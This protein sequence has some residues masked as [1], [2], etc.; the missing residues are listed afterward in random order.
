[1]KKLAHSARRLSQRIHYDFDDITLLE[2]ALTHS[3]TR[4]AHNERLEFLGDAV[5]EVIIS[6]ALFKQHPEASEGPLTRLRANLVCERSLV[7]IAVDLKLGDYLHL[8]QGEKKS[9]GARRD[10]ILADA[11]EALIGAIYLDSDLVCCEKYVLAWFADKLANSK[12]DTPGLK[13]PKST[14][15]EYAQSRGQTLPIYRIEVIEG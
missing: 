15:Q 6:S 7:D 1:M 13:D 14:L 4:Q 12:I 2:T 3:S 5:L 9:G 11:V 10:S 8:G